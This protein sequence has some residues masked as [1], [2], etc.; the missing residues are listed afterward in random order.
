MLL[1]KPIVAT[2]SNFGHSGQPPTHPE[3]LDH[4]AVRFM[5][6]G[7]RIKPLIREIVTSAT[8]CQSSTA[9]PSS[10]DPANDY[11][12]RAHRRR[13]TVEQWRDTLLVVAGNLQ[14]A[15]AGKSPELADPGN[16]HRTLYAN[17]SRLKLDDLLTQFDY[18]D[19]NVH[20]EKRAVTNTPT[21]KLFALNSPFVLQQ[22]RAFAARLATEF[23]DD[24]DDARRIRQA[25]RLLFARTPDD[26]ELS[27]GL[28]FLARPNTAPTL[29]RWQQYAQALLASNETLY[30]D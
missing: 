19:A 20:A 8:Y 3:L 2:P 11:L 26:A 6:G 1:G 7:W 4:L 10:S 27:L 25:Y 17:I 16:R 30:V 9:A 13:M 22:A 12:A 24:G 21:Q 23:P 29:T 15:P 14:P 28:N 18:P 5:D